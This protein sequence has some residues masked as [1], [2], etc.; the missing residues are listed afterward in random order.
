MS[1]LQGYSIGANALRNLEI[2]TSTTAEDISEANNPNHARKSILFRDAPASLEINGKKIVQLANGL[3]SLIVKRIHDQVIDTNLTQAQSKQSYLDNFTQNL[4]QI[5]SVLIQ[6][7]SNEITQALD[8]FF[9][10]ASY[11]SSNPGQ[12]AS[13]VG[14][15]NAGINLAKTVQGAFLQ[16]QDQLT[17]L[18]Q[19][20]VLTIDQ[21]NDY[22]S[23]IK[24]LNEAILKTNATGADA[25]AL[26]D[27]RNGVL[28]DLSKLMGF[29]TIENAPDATWVFSGQLGLVTGTTTVLST[30]GYSA[31]NQTVSDGTNN[32]TV[33]SGKLLGLLQ[34][35]SSIQNMQANLNTLAN[36][37]KTEV[38]TIHETGTNSL[39]KTNIQ[40]FND[41]ATGQLQTGASDF[42]VNTA[43]VTDPDVIAS[44]VSGNPGDGGVALSLSTL[45]SQSIASLSNSTFDQYTRNFTSSL[46]EQIGSQKTSLATQEAIL[47]QLQNQK[48][49][50]SGVSI[51]E[52]MLNLIRYQRSLQ[53]IAEVLKRTDQITDNMIRMAST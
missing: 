2:A 20:I 4:G 30:S 28:Q 40:F 24:T 39:G 36:H 3:G 46:G 50:I 42:S 16:L 18:N 6:N 14:L 10:A 1:L 27:Q 49:S 38:N 19:Q 43:I 17:T 7:G 44:G 51:D 8:Q 23:E 41:V 31:T 11:L 15:Q 26:I 22:A 12:Y 47:T 35:A 25:S 45:R 21:I 34:S 9:N 52:S 48:D 33:T 5:E 37:L 32:Y 13:R 53:A 29:Q